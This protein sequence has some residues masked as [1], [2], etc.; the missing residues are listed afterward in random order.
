[1]KSKI[2]IVDHK[3]NEKNKLIDILAEEYEVVKA[4]DAY[5]AL[6]ALNN[7]PKIQVVLLELLLP[8]MSGL[9]LL[10][11]LRSNSL[12]KDLVILVVAETGNT[13]EEI[14]AL[15]IGADD[16][17]C[18]PVAAEVVSARIKHILYNREILNSSECRFSLQRNL[19]DA[20][21]TAV[22]VVDAIN[23]NLLYANNASQ[24]L[25]QASDDNYAGRK[26]YEYFVNRKFPCE[27]C[28]LFIAHTKEN[29]AEVF[30]PK[31]TKTVNISVNL[32]EWLT[33]PAYVVY[34]NDVTEEKHARQLAE[35]RYQKELRRRYRVDMDFMAYLVF[36]VTTGSVIEHDPHGFPVPTIYPGQPSSEFVE[37]VLPT[38]IDYEKR[39][40]FTEIM[41]LD[42]LRRAFQEGKT[43]L[44][45][46]YRRYSRNMKNIMW[47]RSTIQL[48]EDPQ[49]KDLI[50]FLYT[51]DINENKMMQEVISK[52]VNYDYNMI[53]DI[54][55]FS[56]SA[57][58]YT[59][60]GFG[61]DMLPKQEFDYQNAIEQYVNSFVVKQEREQVL[62]K[63]SLENVRQQLKEKDSYEF[64]INKI[65]NSGQHRKSK[66]RYVYLDKVYGMVLWT[67]RDI[68]HIVNE[69]QQKQKELLEQ[70]EG[71]K[72]LN[73]VK[74]DYLST[75]GT[76]VRMPLKNIL[77]TLKKIGNIC[78]HDATKG[79]LAGIKYQL[80]KISDV[81]NDIM[82]ISNLEMQKVKFSEVQFT[83]S[84]LVA[85]VT[86]NIKKKYLEKKITIECVE[87]VFHNSCLGDY[88]AIYKLLYNILD[89]ACKFSGDNSDVQIAVYELPFKGQN[90][91][92]YRFV[93]KDN[94]CGIDTETMQHV[95]TPFS[96]YMNETGCKD[97]SGLGLSIAKIIVERLGGTI[98]LESQVGAGTTV[99][100]DLH[101]TFVDAIVK[102]A[103]SKLE[104]QDSIQNKCLMLVRHNPLEVLVLRKLLESKGAKVYCADTEKEAVNLLESN[105]TD[106]FQYVVVDVDEL[107]SEQK[108]SILRQ[109]KKHPKLSNAYL[110]ALCSN[111]DLDEKKALVES[112]VCEVLFKP[113]RFAG[114][115]N[116]LQEY[117]I[118]SEK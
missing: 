51:Y 67:D 9:E 60:N 49:S 72:E 69:E 16:Y 111:A 4:E 58:V 85:T 107:Q 7:D 117:Q 40:E 102:T 48:M 17:I 116:I 26:C 114:L 104:N 110:F 39:K 3:Q 87:Q 83:L 66:I 64:D 79:Q 10:Q 86:K 52:A 6:E 36:N 105:Y 44:S 98:G 25:L 15:G 74:S 34:M 80:T 50:A 103:A 11:K 96:I 2:L 61:I 47:A 20:M 55:L 81:I 92:F 18:Q 8:K 13:H 28:K 46:D 24:K 41:K 38:V 115:M 29:K 93:I 31:V 65:D 94:G 100:I 23:H 109:L 84:D 63:M 35:E 22:F 42:N 68:S 77:N 108:N 91:A 70:V 118:R 21:E 71:L 45:I 5:Q 113:L 54:N 27:K 89:N 76:S 14:T 88:K 59:S 82:I 30:I 32:M 97:S 57:K 37:R 99:T 1:M 106:F 78:S 19:L 112:G 90:E 53:A 43:V 75:F 101:M 56:R 33:R 12:Y 62:Q 95:F 73:R